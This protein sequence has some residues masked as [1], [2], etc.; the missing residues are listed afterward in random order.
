M[1]KTFSQI[2]E[3]S[4]EQFPSLGTVDSTFVWGA[5]LCTLAL[6]ISL[7]SAHLDAISQ[8]LPSVS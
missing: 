3:I 4:S 5:V 7:A 1:V 2:E 8:V 6:A